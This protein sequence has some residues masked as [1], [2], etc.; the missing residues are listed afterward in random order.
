MASMGDFAELPDAESV[1][2]NPG[3]SAHSAPCHT[4]AMEHQEELMK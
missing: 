2:G 1:P 4:M 3:A